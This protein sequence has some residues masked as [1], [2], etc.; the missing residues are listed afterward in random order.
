[1]VSQLKR[2]DFLRW[3]EESKHGCFWQHVLCLRLLYGVINTGQV[4]IM[5]NTLTNCTIGFAFAFGVFE[6]YYRDL[7]DFQ[8][9]DMVAVIGTCATVRVPNL[10]PC[11]S[12]NDSHRESPI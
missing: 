9:S 5:Q 8:G 10:T 7:E 11:P 6:K 1:M 2:K 4:S 12:A 3:M